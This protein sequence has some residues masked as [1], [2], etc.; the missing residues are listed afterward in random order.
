MLSSPHGEQILLS[1]SPLLNEAC[2]SLEITAGIWRCG[3]VSSLPTPWAPELFLRVLLFQA[4]TRLRFCLPL[5]GA[6]R[7]K[8]PVLK[9]QMLVFVDICCLQEKKMENKN[10][11]SKNRVAKITDTDAGGES[12]SHSC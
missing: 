11:Q 12:N 7:E 1:A 3:L 2:C 8:Y 9:M 10:T 4:D 6:A 5:C